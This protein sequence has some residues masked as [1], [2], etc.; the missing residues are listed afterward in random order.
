MFGRD[1]GAGN[2]VVIA[3]GA[4]GVAAPWEESSGGEHRFK[5]RLSRSRTNDVCIRLLEQR[6]ATHQ[7]AARAAFATRI[8]VGDNEWA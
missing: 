7:V 6:P 2:D 4:P 8:A 3:F 1:F 5:S